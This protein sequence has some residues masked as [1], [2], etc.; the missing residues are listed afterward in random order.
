MKSSSVIHS[1]D[2]FSLL[3]PKPES[4]ITPK[5]RRQSIDNIRKRD[6]KADR[7]IL[8]LP[9][10]TTT[11]SA[12]LPIIK[13]LSS[14]STSW[15]TSRVRCR[16]PKV[17]QRRD[18]KKGGRQE[19]DKTDGTR[20]DAAIEF[21]GL[22]GVDSK[23]VR[24][25]VNDLL[26]VYE[27][28]WIFIEEY[29]YRVLIDTIF[30]PDDIQQGTLALE[31]SFGNV[32]TGFNVQ[33]DNLLEEGEKH[34]SICEASA[35][36]LE[37]EFPEPKLC[38]TSVE[39]GDKLL[40][41]GESSARLEIACVEPYSSSTSVD[42][43]YK[44]TTI[45]K[46]SVTATGLEIARTKPKS[47]L[48]SEPISET[49]RTHWKSLPCSSSDSKQKRPRL[50]EIIHFKVQSPPRPH[51][52]VPDKV[53]RSHFQVPDKVS[54][55]H[56]QPPVQSPP[57]PHFQAPV[58]SSPLSHFQ[59]PVQSSP[60]PHF[61]AP[62]QIPPPPHFQATVQSCPP[63][64][65]Q[66]TV[67]NCPPP[68]FQATVQSCPPP[69]FQATVQNCPPPNFQATVQSCPPPNFQAPV[70]T[71]PPPHFQAP[72]QIPPSPNFQAP[73][74]SCPPSHFQAPVQIPP[75]LHFQV[76]VQI[77]PPPH[78]QVSVQSCP[79]PHVQAPVQI[80]PSPH[81]QA[82]VQI[83]P[84][85]RRKPCWGWIDENEDGDVEEN[86]VFSESIYSIQRQARRAASETKRERTARWDVKPQIA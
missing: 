25:A 85:P 3:N 23:V 30:P 80:P 7:P 84:H 46:T 77:P 50:E 61:Q 53:S 40:S 54:R 9:P 6:G 82:P 74:Q 76:P 28:N 49:G 17:P 14:H 13:D 1:N 51:F 15:K 67:Q 83:P 70:Q 36:G 21:L 47:S 58:Q 75:P 64:N 8:V 27:G 5:Q 2:L 86:C 79:P 10:M 52:Q 63:P 71:C 44:N 18:K 4:N 33:K 81:F 60:P 31:E 55:P 22:M 19:Q 68:N 20:M 42:E 35:T 73:V 78:F 37:I 24:K 38:I 66:A 56:F 72:V 65:F 59:A 11:L 62:V 12:I 16:Y 34:L 57:P 29:G 69:N 43:G 39:V 45:R 26:K 32:L 41:I 48:T